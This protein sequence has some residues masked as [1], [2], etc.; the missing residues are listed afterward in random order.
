MQNRG[1][2]RLR[3]YSLLHLDVDAAK[4]SLENVPANLY[5]SVC[6]PDLGDFLGYQGGH[7]V[8][9]SEH[10]NPTTPVGSAAS[11]NPSGPPQSSTQQPAVQQPSSG[12]VSL[13]SRQ[14]HNDG[15]FIFTP[16]H[17]A[18]RARDYIF[19][20]WWTDNFSLNA[21]DISSHPFPDSAN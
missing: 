4:A 21:F 3:I 1:V 5:E 18:F 9:A 19:C 7:Q 17:R 20:R 2:S 15:K 14:Y 16:F 8:A 13:P 12:A 11:N 10:K 6:V